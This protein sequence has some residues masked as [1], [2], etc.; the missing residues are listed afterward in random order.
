M[1]AAGYEGCVVSVAKVKE[2]I[3]NI[4]RNEKKNI[5][6]FIW[7]KC[8]VLGVAGDEWVYLALL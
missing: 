4:I 6:N 1:D 8:S 3:Q 7:N 5:V 2:I